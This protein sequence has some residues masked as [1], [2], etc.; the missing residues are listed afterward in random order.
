MCVTHTLALCSS[1][2][3]WLWFRVRPTKNAPTTTTTKTEKNGAANDDDDDDVGFG[4]SR[5]DGD[6][7]DA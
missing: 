1:S 2:N 4:V 6:D 3:N 7:D 5:P